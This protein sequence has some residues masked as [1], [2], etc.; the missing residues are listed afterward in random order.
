MTRDSSERAALDRLG[1]WRSGG[2]SPSF[3]GSGDARRLLRAVDR[4]PLVTGCTLVRVRL[5]ASDRGTLVRVRERLLGEEPIVGTSI[6]RDAGPD[7]PG[8]FDILVVPHCD[9]VTVGRAIADVDEV[10]GVAA[11]TFESPDSEGRPSN[12]VSEPTAAAAT[13]RG[14]MDDGYADPSTAGNSPTVGV[15]AQNLDRPLLEGDGDGDLPGLPWARNHPVEPATDDQAGPANGNQ[16]EPANGEGADPASCPWSSA[17]SVGGLEALEDARG[18]PRASG[19][20]RAASGNLPNGTGPNADDLP[21][22]RRR[23]ANGDRRASPD[24]D[25]PASANGG[26]PAERLDREGSTP[27]QA[28]PDEPVRPI[29]VSEVDEHDE[30]L[31]QLDGRLTELEATLDSLEPSE[32]LGNQSGPDDDHPALD[33]LD[34]RLSS[35][36]SRIAELERCQRRML[37][38]LMGE[39]H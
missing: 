32:A 10:V 31:D 4:S 21:A 12:V 27:D 24:R 6:G 33:E 35:L 22:D 2:E 39:S 9:P 19:G 11:T 36:A 5:G 14:E 26:L 28:A 30:R 34:D 37:D 16:P 25:H 8:T 3:P 23:R 18:S 7:D 17:A 38:A 20:S 29:L 13:S 1:T 15:T